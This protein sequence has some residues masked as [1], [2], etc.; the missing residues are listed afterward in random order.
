MAIQQSNNTPTTT[1]QSNNAAFSQ[2]LNYFNTQKNVKAT[3]R[4]KPQ[5]RP[6]EETHK[7]RPAGSLISKNNHH[8][9]GTVAA[10]CHCTGTTDSIMHAGQRALDSDSS[11]GSITRV[12]HTPPVGGGKHGGTC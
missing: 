3:L 5:R 9:T 7:K 4:N 6:S 1:R 8:T 11:D 2:F 12:E 10:M